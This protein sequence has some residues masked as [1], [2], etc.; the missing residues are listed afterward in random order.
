M[1]EEIEREHILQALDESWLP[2]ESARI[3]ARAQTSQ[4]VEDGPRGEVETIK[5]ALAESRGRVSGPS[6]A[7]VKLG[8]PP[9]T[10]EY[11]IKAL[12]ILKS[13][14]KFRAAALT[15]ILL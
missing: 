1:L 9:S 12:K 10:L 15:P 4:P 6:G 5:A 7:A 11:R 2:K 8:I 13:Q 3:A 14:F